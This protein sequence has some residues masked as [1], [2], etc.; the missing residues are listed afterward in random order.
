MN[1]TI[2]EAFFEK[3]KLKKEEEAS[4]QEASDEP[5]PSLHKI[6]KTKLRRDHHRLAYSIPRR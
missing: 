4:I 2:G 6:S 5:P 1:D 3:E